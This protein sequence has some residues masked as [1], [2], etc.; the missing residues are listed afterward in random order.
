MKNSIQNPY[1]P[2]RSTDHPGEHTAWSTY[3]LT[4]KQ[5]L[6]AE[7]V[8]N[9][10]NRDGSPDVL[11]LQSI[12]DGGYEGTNLAL[13]TSSWHAPFA[14][15]RRFEFS[16]FLDKI[17]ALQKRLAKQDGKELSRNAV[18]RRCL[19]E[20]LREQIQQEIS[21]DLQDLDQ[22]E[23]VPVVITDAGIRTMVDLVLKKDPAPTH[24]LFYAVDIIYNREFPGKAVKA[25]YE[26]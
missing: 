1:F 4:K 24:L 8:A 20:F 18:P 14:F 2:S 9:H 12:F 26:I 6:M 15:C 22:P 5:H 13:E 10:L 23:S 16:L 19:E 3:S 25:L 21:P 7:Q 11:A 17:D